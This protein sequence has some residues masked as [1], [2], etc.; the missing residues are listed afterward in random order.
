M[1]E[2]TGAHRVATSESWLGYQICGHK[3]LPGKCRSDYLL[4][5]FWKLVS[6]ITGSL[7][8]SQPPLLHPVV[9]ALSVTY[10]TT[11]SSLPFDASFRAQGDGI[12]PS[13]LSVIMFLVVVVKSMERSGGLAFSTARFGD[14][15]IQPSG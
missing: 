6:L 15:E 7:L 5:L 14:C 4:I 2:R 9:V 1:V 11:G 10:I 3:C 8:P 12:M 13:D